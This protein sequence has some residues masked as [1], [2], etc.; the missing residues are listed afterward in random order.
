MDQNNLKKIGVDGN[1]DDQVLRL[2]RLARSSGL[3]GVVASASEVKLIRKDI[4]KDFLIVTPGVR[5]AWAAKDD[6]KRVAT[7]KEAVACGADLIVVGR[8]IIEAPD[9]VDAAKRIVKEI[10]EA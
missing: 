9:P 3:D 7:P 4:G 2:A 5:P 10:S 8:P 6:Q 1:M